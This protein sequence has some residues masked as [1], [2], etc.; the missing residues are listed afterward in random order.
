[1]LEVLIG[2]VIVV[3]SFAFGYACNAKPKESPIFNIRVKVPE[4]KVTHR[5]AAKAVPQLLDNTA[6]A[7]AYEK[8]IESARGIKKAE[9]MTEEYKDLN[10]IAQ[11][12]MD[13]YME[14]NPIK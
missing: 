11:E 12:L 13:D 10:G 7:E 2:L 5:D 14:G 9:E 6:A 8:A 4:I 1:M 3:V